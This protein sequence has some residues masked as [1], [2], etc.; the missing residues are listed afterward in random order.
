MSCCCCCDIDDVVDS[1][2]DFFNRMKKEVKRFIKRGRIKKNHTP[3]FKNVRQPVI[4]CEC[5]NKQSK[6]D[7]WEAAQLGKSLFKQAMGKNSMTTR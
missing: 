6:V 5:A 2:K 3:I 1:A 7:A 4:K